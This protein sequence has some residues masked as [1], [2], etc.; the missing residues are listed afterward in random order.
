[1]LNFRCIVFIHEH[2]GFN[3]NWCIIIRDGSVF[4]ALTVAILAAK[5]Q[6]RH[7]TCVFKQRLR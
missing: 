2:F 1:M 3:F 4:R 5:I 7:Q 6:P